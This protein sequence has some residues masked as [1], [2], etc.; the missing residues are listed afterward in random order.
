MPSSESGEKAIVKAS[1]EQTLDEYTSTVCLSRSLGQ[2]LKQRETAANARTYFVA[3]IIFSAIFEKDMGLIE[4]IAK[5]IDGTVPTSGNRDSFANLMGDAIDD[6]LD[7]DKAEQT[8]VMPDDPVII[9]LAKVVFHIATS[10]TKGN[11]TLKREK[12][13]AVE[14]VYERTN[15]RRVE[16]VRPQ[17]ETVYTKPSWMMEEGEEDEVDT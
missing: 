4:T 6:V 17:I 11:P 9:A 1:Q 10:P 3:D 14:M 12:Q 2:V 5:R 7:M 15:G 13:K 16:P 8:V